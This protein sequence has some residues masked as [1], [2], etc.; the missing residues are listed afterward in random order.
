MIR[1]QSK[2]DHEGGSIWSRTEQVTVKLDCTFLLFYGN[3]MSFQSFFW[4]LNN[5]FK[6]LPMTTDTKEWEKVITFQFSRM[7]SVNLFLQN[8]ITEHTVKWTAYTF[9]PNNNPFLWCVSWV[10]CFFQLDLTWQIVLVPLIPNLWL[11]LI[12]TPVV[13]HW[14]SRRPFLRMS[15]H[16]M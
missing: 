16:G 14:L 11:G 6:A 15:L 5:I 12:C 8:W 7:N 9:L 4:L 2:L 3:K 10:R 1:R 13:H